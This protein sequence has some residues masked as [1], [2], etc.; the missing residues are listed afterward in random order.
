MV[1]N[2]N[3]IPIWVSKSNLILICGHVEKKKLRE[4][5]YHFCSAHLSRLVV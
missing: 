4:R 1:S 2:T 3:L 5:R